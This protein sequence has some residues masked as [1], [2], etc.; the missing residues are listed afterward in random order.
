MRRWLIHL[1][2]GFADY[3]EAIEDI[4]N[5]ESEERYRILALAVKKL[6]S[7]IGV[8][9]ILIQKNKKWLFQGNELSDAEQKTLKAQAQSLLGSKL[10][11]ILKNEVVYHANRKM[12]ILSRTTDDMVAGKLWLYTFDTLETRLQRMIKNDG[13]EKPIA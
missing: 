6:F 11:T 5:K 3:D 8:E 13:I 12:F 4:K 2:K 1:F 9:D 10:W 7:T